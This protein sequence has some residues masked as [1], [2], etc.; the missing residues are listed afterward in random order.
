MTLMRM[1]LIS[2]YVV[3]IRGKENVPVFRIFAF[4]GVDYLFG[5]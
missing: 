4:S 3:S 5:S 1:S 2:Y